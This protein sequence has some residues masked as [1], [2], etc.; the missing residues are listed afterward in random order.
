MV[1][2]NTNLKNKKFQLRFMPVSPKLDM[3]E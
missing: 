3:T 1:E 2:Y